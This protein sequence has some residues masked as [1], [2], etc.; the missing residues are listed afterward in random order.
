[1]LT[2]YGAVNIQVLKS[3]FQG[4]FTAE[5]VCEWLSVALICPKWV[6]M[7]KMVASI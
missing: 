4:G 2:L 5:R 1:M 3:S 7:L 6:N